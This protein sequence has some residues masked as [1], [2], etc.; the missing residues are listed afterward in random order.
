MLQVAC[1]MRWHWHTTWLCATPYG[2]KTISFS[3]AGELC[4]FLVNARKPNDNESVVSQLEE[5]DTNI[6]HVG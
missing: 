4:F 2:K 6:S 1:H 5:S 3:S